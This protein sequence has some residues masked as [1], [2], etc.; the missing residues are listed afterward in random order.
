MQVRPVYNAD[1]FRLP[2]SQE[3]TMHDTHH[4]PTSCGHLIKLVPDGN[5][6]EAFLASWAE[7]IARWA[8]GIEI[9][10]AFEAAIENIWGDWMIDVERRVIVRV[11]D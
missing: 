2:F 10:E 4:I 8:P 3:Q 1:R 6:R 5:E 11:A 7:A 9:N